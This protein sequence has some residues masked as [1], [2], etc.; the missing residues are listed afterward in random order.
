MSIRSTRFQFV[1]A[2]A[3]G[4]L[5]ALV[6][7]AHAAD[8]APKALEDTAKVMAEQFKAMGLGMTT[9][10][11]KA[12]DAAMSKHMAGVAPQMD[13]MGKAMA[14]SID[15]PEMRASMDKIA[16][17]MSGTMAKQLP[18]MM[19]AMQPMMAEMLPRMLRMQADMMQILF[20]G[21]APVTKTE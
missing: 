15:T 1:L 5:L 11:Q 21:T 14:K 2:M 12:M 20:S 19:Q 17:E 18:A 4:A 3:A 7:P 10:K 16:K 6:S 13:D 8:P 9:E